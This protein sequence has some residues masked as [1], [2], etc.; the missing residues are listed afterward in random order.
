MRLTR[1]TDYALRVLIY[2]AAHDDRTCAIAEIAKAYGISY[3]HLMKV[4][5]TLGR[6][7]FVDAVRGRGGGLRLSR[8]ADRIR[9]GDVVRKTEEGLELADCASC[10]IAPACGLTSVL[11]QGVQAMLKVFDRFTV[12]DLVKKQIALRALF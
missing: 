3:N 12:A 4:V 6:E 1:Y 8:P 7:G 11:A 2:L 5:N 10:L 9:V